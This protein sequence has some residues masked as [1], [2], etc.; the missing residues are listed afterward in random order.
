V[1]CR[2]VGARSRAPPYFRISEG[3][4]LR[5]LITGHNGYI[6]SVMTRVVRDAGHEVRG[7]D[8]YFFEQCTF[9]EEPV[10]PPAAR[11]D[12]RDAREAQLA[13]YDAIIHLAALSND[14]LGD[15]DASLTYDINHAASLRLAELAKAAGVRR[16]L[17]ASSCSL[18]GVAGT[19]MLD[20]TAS[21][22][23]ITPYG[24]S[25]VR[26]ERDLHALA[27]D[28]F[29]PTYL[30][31]ATAYGLSPRLRFDVVV[32]NLVGVALATGEIRVQSDGTPWRPLVHVEDFSR[33]FLAVLEAPRELVH[34]QAFNVG[35]TEENYQVRDLADLV[36]Q[37]LPGTEVRYAEGGGPDPRSYRVNCDKLARTLPRFRP[38]WTVPK[39]IAELVAGFRAHGL[40]REDFEGPRYVRLRRIKELQRGGR[41]D[42]SLRWVGAAAG[43]EAGEGR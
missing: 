30:R 21:F 38:Q 23:P 34:D 13:G 33:A 39:G 3:V 8:T 6:G 5:V 7:L 20:E 37:A 18:Y 27:D 12:L 2:E 35:R 10:D 16:F 17:F 31:N 1:F 42:A 25:K 9:G 11:V 4:V 32:N 28:R 15:L 24:E 36:R 22:N 43:R 19:G 41:L 14:P 40:T 26:M 29:S